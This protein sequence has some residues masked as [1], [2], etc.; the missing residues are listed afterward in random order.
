[1]LLRTTAKTAQSNSM[2]FDNRQ[3]V[4]RNRAYASIY[5][6]ND[7]KT[8]EVEK[9]CYYY[10]THNFWVLNYA[11]KGEWIYVKFRIWMDYSLNDT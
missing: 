4:D 10:K 9:Q 2:N 6:E 1:M 11:R 3:I 5:R 7:G 8:S